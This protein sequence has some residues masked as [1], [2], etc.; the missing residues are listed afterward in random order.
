M[1]VAFRTRVGAGAV[2]LAILLVAG[3]V[4]VAVAEGIPSG[5]VA[6]EPIRDRS[7]ATDPTREANGPDRAARAEKKAPR[8]VG[9]DGGPDYYG[10]FSHSLPTSPSFFP[11]GVWGAYDMTAGNVAL[12]KAVGLNTYVWFADT[13]TSGF[14]ANA[15]RAGMHL[16][17]NRG[18]GGSQIGS[19]TFGRLLDDEVD[20]TQ[21]ADACPR[22]VDKAKGSLPKDGRARYANYGKGVLVWGASGVDGHNDKTSACFV[23]SQ[24]ITSTDLY[25]H[26]DPYQAGDRYS[27]L[28]SGYGWSMRR[29]RKL[30]AMDGR[31]SPQWGFVEVTNAMNGPWGAPEPAE[32][33]SAVW[34][35]LIA[36][37]R[38]VI[39]FQ[40]DFEGDCVTHHALRESGSPCYG[41]TV[42]AVRSVNRQIKRLS[43]VLNAPFVRGGYRL[44][45]DAPG[46]VRVSVKR[47]KGKVWVLA[48]AD[49]GA[50][51]ARFRMRCLGNATAKVMFEGRS[52]S[53]RGG[54]FTDRFSSK[55]DV[56]IYRIDG[57]SSCGLR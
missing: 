30:D 43:P 52:V 55:D 7:G 3:V 22:A 54:S 12:D 42:R 49:K 1:D 2:A 31:R 46:K 25:W 41:A 8:L 20:M 38:G 44:T 32:I 39:Y 53:M 28:S 23:N 21:G 57:G 48:A 9:V 36:G 33:R 4:A 11:V 56:H 24:D 35:T 26:T 17:V 16:I 34:H 51:T 40:H 6:A 10:R 15:R 37:A 29:M 45:D 5:S 27:G 50:G 14:V 13:T 19:E 47:A 18:E